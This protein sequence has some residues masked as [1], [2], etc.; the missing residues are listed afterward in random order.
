MKGQ[1]YPVDKRK[2]VRERR[3][4][5]SELHSVEIVEKDTTCGR[6]QTEEALMR[7]RKASLN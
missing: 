4:A 3:R 7:H 5:P 1:K 2:E 6:L